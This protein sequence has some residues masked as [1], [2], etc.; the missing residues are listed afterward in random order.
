M[1]TTLTMSVMLMR[2]PLFS[3]VLMFMASTLNIRFRRNERYALAFVSTSLGLA[4]S[5]WF[6]TAL[7]GLSLVDL[8]IFWAHFKDVMV[9]IMSH[10]PPEWPVMVS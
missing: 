1:A 7:L 10:T 4:A 2:W 9:D 8:S 6:A 3:A 5:C